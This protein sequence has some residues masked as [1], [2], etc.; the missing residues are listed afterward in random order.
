MAAKT[1][2]QVSSTLLL[3]STRLYILENGPRKI[4]FYSIYKN[5][6]QSA[7]LSY[8]I[9]KSG[10]RLVNTIVPTL[11]LGD[12]EAWCSH[13]GKTRVPEAQLG[14]WRARLAGKGGR[15]LHKGRFSRVWWLRWQRTRQTLKVPSYS[16]DSMSVI[17]LCKCS[18]NFLLVN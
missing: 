15:R 7:L 13:S 2:D 18:R 16:C 12:K 17:V 11:L 6:S 14:H 3:T 10:Q 1:K 5:A 9:L 8:L 4:F